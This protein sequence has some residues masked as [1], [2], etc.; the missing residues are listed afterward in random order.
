MQRLMANWPVE[1]TRANMLLSEYRSIWNDVGEYRFRRAVD[2]IVATAA[3][4]FFPSQA[5]FRGYI[6]SA[7]KKRGCGKCDSGWIMIPDPVARGE[8]GDLNATMALRCECRRGP[9]YQTW[10][11]SP[12]WRPFQ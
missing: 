6:P 12:E 7:G 10:R 8:Y 5:E 4:Q 1:A 9:S 2:S 11:E 3:L